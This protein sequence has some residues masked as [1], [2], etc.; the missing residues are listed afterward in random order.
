MYI[1]HNSHTV[2]SIATTSPG[3]PFKIHTLPVVI[4]DLKIHPGTIIE[5]QINIMRDW[6][7]CIANPMVYFFMGYRERWHLMIASP[8]K[9]MIWGPILLKMM[10]EGCNL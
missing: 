4:I 3:C 1:Y 2:I 7:E 6:M 8:H 5:K 10:W 9:L